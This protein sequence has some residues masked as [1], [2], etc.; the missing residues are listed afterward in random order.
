MS[1][2][3]H[4]IKA[5]KGAKHKKKIIGRGNASGH[6]TYSTRGQKG[7]KS[8]SGGSKGLKR[9]GLRQ[10]ILSFPKMRGFKSIHPKPA[11]LNL[12]DLEKISGNIITPKIILENGLVREIKNGVK[13]LGDG[14]IKRAVTVKECEVSGSARE[15]IEKAGGHIQ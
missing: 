9:K 5:A 12:K 11:V 2:A 15:K 6:G 4:T 7:Q 1:L 14:E 10:L 13:I 8:R 3:L